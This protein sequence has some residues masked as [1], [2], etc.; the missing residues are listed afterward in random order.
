ML[1]QFIS[2]S[3]LPAAFI[4][5]T[6]CN[7]PVDTNPPETSA[8][9]TWHYALPPV[10]GITTDTLNI[11]L[12]IKNN[13]SYSLELIERADKLLYSSK[14]TW[15]ATDDSIF[16]TGNDCHILDT[17]TDPD[18]IVVL[19]DTTCEKPIPLGLP[20]KTDKWTVE[21]ASLASMLVAFPIPEALVEQIPI[22][23]PEIPLQKEN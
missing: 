1:R 19:D 16:L 23:F 10:P 15:E 22:F 11:W 14:G 12:E 4:V 8:T 9:G 3:L 5:I 17:S 18:S 7:D 13:E 21:T 6:A 2:L 20:E